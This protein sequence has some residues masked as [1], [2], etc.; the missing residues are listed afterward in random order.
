MLT[1]IPLCP[2]YTHQYMIISKAKI[3]FKNEIERLAR[4]GGEKLLELVQV[5]WQQFVD[6]GEKQLFVR[7]THQHNLYVAKLTHKLATNS[8]W[9]DESSPGSC[10]RANIDPL[11]LAMT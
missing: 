8:A 1:K 7:W 10:L 6:G 2:L 3:T 11:E 4:I 9:R 5:E